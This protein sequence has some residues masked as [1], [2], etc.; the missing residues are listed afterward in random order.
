MGILHDGDVNPIGS[1][2]CIFKPR[3]HNI[4]HHCCYWFVEYREFTVS[5]GCTAR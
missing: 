2:S 5:F 3:F 4:T 1:S